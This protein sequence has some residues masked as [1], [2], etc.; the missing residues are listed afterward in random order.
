MSSKTPTPSQV[1]IALL[2]AGAFV[3]ACGPRP[4]SEAA[5]STTS[6]A[7]AA[8][9]ELQ[10]SQHSHGENS[11]LATR[12]E[13]KVQGEGVEF[14]LDVT[15]ESKKHIEL[16]F[17][18]GQ[19]HEFVVVDSVGREIWRWSTSRLFTQAVQNKLLSSGESMRV[20]ERWDR[21]TRHGKY[22]AIATLNS[23]NFPVQERAEF[24]LP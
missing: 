6:L 22:T 5:A 1:A 15:N 10:G 20:A 16:A 23:T 24:V 18:N 19:T 2:C 11:R 17:P 4:H 3:F 14:A 7:S 21:P 8:T 9:V 13:I 12:L